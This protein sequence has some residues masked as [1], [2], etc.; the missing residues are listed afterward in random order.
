MRYIK[1]KKQRRN[2]RIGSSPKRASSGIFKNSLRIK[3][4]F[5]SDVNGILKSEKMFHKII[6]SLFQG[7]KPRVKH[8][9]VIA[10]KTQHE[11]QTGEE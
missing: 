2:L 9:A 1:A 6:K 11:K 3:K 5:C 7:R 8:G 4:V 10:T